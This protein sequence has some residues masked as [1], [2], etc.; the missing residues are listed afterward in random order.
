MF[1]DNVN[2]VDQAAER[3][4]FG[5]EPDGDG[6]GMGT[7]TTEVQIAFT[8][9][10]DNFAWVVPVSSVPELFT[11]NDALFTVL[12]NAT[13]P[14]HTLVFEEFRTCDAGGYGRPANAMS[15]SA[16]SVYDG[17][18]SGGVS[19]L[20]SQTVGPYDTVILQA[21][22]SSVLVEWLQTEGYGIPDNIEPAVR[23]YVAAE[24]Y[25][26]ALKLSSSADTGD[27][28]PLG[29]RYRGTTASIPIQLTAVAT[30]PDLPLEVFV[31]GPSRAVPDN[32]LHVRLNDAS[33]DWYGGG[34]NYRDVV[35]LAADEA[36]GQA[37]ATDYSGPASIMDGRLWSVGMID[38]GD[39]RGLESPFDWIQTINFSGLPA[40][41]QLVSLIVSLVPPPAGVSD[42]DFLSCPECYASASDYPDFD[43]EVATDALEAAVIDPLRDAQEMLDGSVHLTRLFTTMDA[44]EMTADPLFVFNED[45]DQDVNPQ[46]IAINEVHCGVFEGDHA[47]RVLALE[48][49]RRISLPSEAWLEEKEL[50]EFEYMEEL[51]TPAALVIEDLGA[52]G[53]GEILFDYREQAFADAKAF[54]AGCGC[55]TTPR[56]SQ[57]AAP[58]ILLLAGL[59]IRR[60]RV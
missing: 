26:V 7:I 55:S 16:G 19:V 44:E 37:F 12:A 46:H 34:L 49:G 5:F 38:L 28:A 45:L 35:R 30:I 60:R 40:S 33:I 36:G 11:S 31:L 10:S 24:Q 59:A 22:D 47:E 42:S 48:D 9:E 13:L 29:M 15:D 25:F 41:S 56:L 50:T 51:R 1:C 14:I 43:A 57:V 58:A 20:A 2:P 17:S 4:V 39:L 18:T 54:G 8:G 32:Y 23:P 21:N 52:E 27:L 3:I 6:S 53:E